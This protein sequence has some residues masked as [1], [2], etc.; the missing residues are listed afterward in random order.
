MPSNPT[1]SRAP[2]CS[3]TYNEQTARDSCGRGSRGRD[4]R[5]FRGAGRRAVLFSGDVG[6]WEKPLLNDPVPAPDAD[7][8]VVESTYGDRL[9]E[10]AGQVMEHLAAVIIETRRR[11]GNIIVPSFALVTSI[12]G[13]WPTTVTVS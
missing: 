11:G 6:R 4:R 7:W 10:H 13:D 1:C 8:I 2:Q 12:V 3:I 9:H 5:C